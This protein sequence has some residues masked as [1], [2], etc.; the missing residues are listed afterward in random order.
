M[1]VDVLAA[2][3]SLAVL[4]LVLVPVC[5]APLLSEKVLTQTRKSLCV[6]CGQVH[7]RFAQRCPSDGKGANG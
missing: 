6:D 5:T 2:L 3:L 1:M 7:P 4:L